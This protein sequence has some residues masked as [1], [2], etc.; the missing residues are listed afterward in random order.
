MV[1]YFTETQEQPLPDVGASCR[2]CN[3][4]VTIAEDSYW[5]INS[6]TDSTWIQCPKDWV[7]YEIKFAVGLNFR[8]YLQY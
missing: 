4:Y 8:T 1:F 2:Q 5:E 3:Q 6:E 7:I